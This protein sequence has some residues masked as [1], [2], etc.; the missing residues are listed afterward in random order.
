MFCSRVLRCRVKENILTHLVLFVILLLKAIF[1]FHIVL[2]VDT[3]FTLQ[4]PVTVQTLCVFIIFITFRSQESPLFF[5]SGIS[6]LFHTFSSGPQSGDNCL[7]TLWGMHA[8]FPKGLLS[9]SFV[10]SSLVLNPYLAADS[11]NHSSHLSY[12][13]RKKTW[14]PVLTGML[15]KCFWWWY[16]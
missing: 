15:I 3:L 4:E 9:A 7:S 8:A 5:P 6:A 12:I 13:S 16:S 1:R 2:E 10:F 14:H 11:L